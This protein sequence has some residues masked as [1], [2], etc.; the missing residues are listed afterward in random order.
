MLRQSEKP[1]VDS[2]PSRACSQEIHAKLETA[3]VVH[4]LN[5]TTGLQKLIGVAKSDQARSL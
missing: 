5:D 1:G 2:Y 3:I 4:K